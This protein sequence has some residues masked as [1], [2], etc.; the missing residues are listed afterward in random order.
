MLTNPK[1][2]LAVSIVSAIAGVILQSGIIVEASP[3]FAVLSFLV[4]TASGIAY[5]KKIA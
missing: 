2:K 3:W 4:S 1:F 5:Q